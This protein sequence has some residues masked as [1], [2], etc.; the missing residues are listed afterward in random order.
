MTITRILV[1]LFTIALAARPALAQQVDVHP[2]KVEVLSTASD[3]I[4]I[5]GGLTTGVQG[6]F[7]AGPITSTGILTVNG[8]GSAF[9]TNQTGIVRYQFRNLNAGTGAGTVID[10]GNN[11]D[12][13]A[14]QLLHTSNTFITSGSVIG[15]AFTLLGIR[16]GGVAISAGHASGTLRLHAGGS[17]AAAVTIDAS[18]VMN[19]KLIRASADVNANAID[20]IGRAADSGSI[21]RWRDSLNASTYGSIHVDPPSALMRLSA[22][23]PA[24][25]VLDLTSSSITAHK[26]IQMPDGVKFLADF[27]VNGGF[28]F[29]G[30]TDTGVFNNGGSVL[31][32]NTDGAQRLFVDNIAFTVFPV[33]V[34]FPNIGTTASAANAVLTAGNSLLRSTSSRRAKKD[35]TPIGAKDARRVVMGL[36]PVT[37]NGIHDYDDR[38]WAGFIAEDVER[39]EE[40]LVT[41]GDDG[42]P[43]YVTYDRVPAYLVRVVQ[44]LEQRLST[45]ESENEKL[46][47]QVRSL[48]LR[49]K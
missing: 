26:D 30:D 17:S 15:D 38:K 7:S 21:I 6:I 46:R 14:G 18:S 3:A 12:Q 10:I 36:S 31:S 45:L 5:F 47:R 11:V 1:L 29:N 32:L 20:M 9:V 37:Y 23:T 24:V 16:A 22:G 33:G 44:D 25:S 39:V 49:Q 19:T 2:D 34:S 35:I 28:A 40:A 43:N 27:G 4:K 48:R 41:Y 42:A 8:N 13:F